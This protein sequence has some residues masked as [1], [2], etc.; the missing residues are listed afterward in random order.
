MKKIIATFPLF[1]LLLLAG[2]IAGCK[3]SANTGKSVNEKQIDSFLYQ[4]WKV[5]S[6]QTGSQA[7]SGKDMGDPLYEFTRTGERIKSYETPPH[8]E[9]TK[10][11]LKQDSITF[12]ENPKL[13]AARISKISKDSLILTNDKAIWRLCK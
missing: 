3:S 12:P 5:H 1:A 8:S 7:V 2:C 10:F 9:S 4:K 11:A 6:I 13:P